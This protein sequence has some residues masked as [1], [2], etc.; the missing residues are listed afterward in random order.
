[1]KLLH[2][3][4][5]TLLIV[6]GLLRRLKGFAVSVGGQRPLLSEQLYLERSCKGSS[7]VISHFRLEVSDDIWH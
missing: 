6:L 1:M 3:P 5:Y 4:A 7:V 2:M